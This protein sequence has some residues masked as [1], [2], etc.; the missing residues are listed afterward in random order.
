MRITVAL[1]SSPAD[2]GIGRHCAK[3]LLYRGATKV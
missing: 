1:P 3:R 2:R